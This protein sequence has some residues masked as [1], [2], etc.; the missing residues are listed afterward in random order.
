[1]AGNPDLMP[2]PSLSILG[3]GWY[4]LPLAMALKREGYPVKGSTTQP[5]KRKQLE[6]QGIEAFQIDLCQEEVPPAFLESDI[7]ICT[8]PPANAENY[9]PAIRRLIAP[10][11]GAATVKEFLFI[12]SIGIY[13][14]RNRIETEA[15]IPLV[16]S[17]KARLLFEAEALCTDVPGLR[18]TIIRFGGLTGPGRDLS[19]YFAGKK[20]IPQG[21]APIN[22]IH[23]DDC[24]GITRAIIEKKAFGRVYHAVH[25]LHPRRADFYSQSC[26]RAGL[27]L[28]EFIPEKTVWKQ[29]DS[30]HI[31]RYLHYTWQRD[32]SRG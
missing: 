15:D 25:P 4:G 1:M 17:G 29:V 7:L 9:I 24:I 8:L 13:E 12:S 16:E 2:K 3:C 14:P 5:E 22:L 26:A 30:I 19:R 6:A 21:H 23:L 31:P 10:L 28:P 32:P 27:E 20:N 11:R 18:S